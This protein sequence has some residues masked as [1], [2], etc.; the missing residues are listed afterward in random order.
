MNN[1][2]QLYK[3]GKKLAEHICAECPDETPD[4]EGKKYMCQRFT[5]KMVAYQLNGFEERF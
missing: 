1:L 4:C 5:D 3:N 2:E